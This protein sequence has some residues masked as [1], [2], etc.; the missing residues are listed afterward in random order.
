MGASHASAAQSEVDAAGDAQ[1]AVVAGPHDPGLLQVLGQTARPLDVRRTPGERLEHLEERRARGEGRVDQVLGPLG[2]GIVGL[3]RGEAGRGAQPFPQGTDQMQLVLTPDHRQR[4]QSFHRG[5]DGRRIRG[6][7]LGQL[8]GRGAIRE[9]GQRLDQVQL[10]QGQSRY[11]PSRGGGAGGAGGQRT[12]PLRKRR[13][14]VRSG[15]EQ[16]LEAVVTETSQR[17]RKGPDR[18]GHGA[19]QHKVDRR[20]HSPIGRG[21]RLK[22]GS[23]RVRV[24]LG[25]RRRANR[26]PDAPPVPGPP[27]ARATMEGMTPSADDSVLSPEQTEL[28]IERID[29]VLARIDA[30][31]ERR[32]RRGSDIEML[33][34]TKS[35]RP[36][37]IAVAIEL[38]R[39]RGPT[40]AVGDN[41][42]QEIAKN[43]DTSRADYGVTRHFIRSL[44]TNEARDVV[45]FAEL[46]LSVDREDIAAAL[47]RRAGMAGVVRDVLVQVNTS[48]EESKGGFAPTV[49]ATAPIIERLR[50]SETLRPVGLMTI[51]ANTSDAAAVR[52]SLSNLR[53]LRDRLRERFDEAQVAHLSMGMSGD[54]EIAVEEGATIVRVGSAI[55]GARP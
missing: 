22:I 18:S 19:F 1:R 38:L 30:A 37:E 5:G 24:P 55:F 39:E 54:L 2:I 43:S 31:A 17:V 6:D 11:G 4:H 42:S 33:L 28:M 44:Q 51:G 10:R 41:R 12:D 35:R 34:A 7:R 47:E 9:D 45:A 46:I 8:A 32:G 52:S 26:C 3:G 23:V 13:G 49:E 14:K 50:A 20:P 48:A 27:P 29:E 40:I 53:M 16:S 15:N 36:A 21:G 25:V